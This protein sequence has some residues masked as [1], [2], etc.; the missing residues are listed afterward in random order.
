MKRPWNIIDLPVYS[1]LSN[2]TN[3]NINMNI[4]TYVSAVSMKPKIYSIAIDFKT[5]TYDNLISCDRVVLQLLSKKNIS[6]VRTLGK[7]SGK[8]IDKNNYLK[9]KKLFNWKGYE[10]LEDVCALVELV[11][12]EE[13]KINGDHHIFL[14][15]AVSYKSFSD[16][17]ILT[18]KD[19]IERK[20]IL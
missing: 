9:K 2:D 13:I 11:K 5:K 14:F 8:K 17:D 7:K 19:L 4:C 10:V 12:S 1:L 18:T 16:K 3:G 15:D 20:I 6:L